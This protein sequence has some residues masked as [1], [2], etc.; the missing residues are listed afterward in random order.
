[1]IRQ[2]LALF[3]DAYRDLNSRKLF[4][5]VLVISTL[6]AA[7]F[8]AIGIYPGGVEFFAWKI[9]WEYLNTRYFSQADFYNFIFDYFGIGVWLS[10]AA[11]ILALISTGGMFPD[12]VAAGAVDLYL[13]KPIGR[14]RLFLTKY[15][16]GLLFVAVQIICFC[17]TCFLVIGLRGGVWEPQLFIAVP[18]VILFFSYLFCV[19]VFLG[20]WT[21]SSIA[22]ILLTLLFWLGV[23]SVDWTER[24]LLGVK[25][26]VQ[27]QAAKS[28]REIAATDASLAN[29]ERIA[30]TRPTTRD[31]ESVR[32][33]SSRLQQQQDNRTTVPT[34]LPVIYQFSY[35]A[36]VLLPKT[37]ATIDLMDRTLVA[38]ASQHVTEMLKATSNDNSSNIG[39]DPDFAK[40]I[41][42][43]MDKRTFG[44][45]VG[46]SLVFEFVN[47]ALAAWLFCRRD[48]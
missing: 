36:M 18:L 37:N 13:S 10:F 29:A 9:Q 5:I 12:F 30:A 22:A 21:R 24:T 15:L 23:H 35:E 3:L 34:Y 32:L 38:S 4:W 45:T 28:D 1:M 47:L 17:A 8:A 11:T 42:T 6:V 43:E 16:F 20:V 48:Y 41:Q 31:T 7:S 26:A 46:T 40:A 19:C 2:T 14:L 39:G 33:L 27:T 44:W 25:V